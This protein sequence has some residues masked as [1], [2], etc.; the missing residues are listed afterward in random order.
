MSMITVDQAWRR[1]NDPAVPVG[2]WR[3]EEQVGIKVAV[4]LLGT[5]IEQALAP[6]IA[7]SM[8]YEV[9]VLDA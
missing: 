2:G 3:L 5:V 6:R 4:P 7:T 9:E 8:R 1:R